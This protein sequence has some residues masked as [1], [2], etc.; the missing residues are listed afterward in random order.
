MRALQQAY[1]AE[2]DVDE[3]MAIL[4]GR[5]DALR[6]QLGVALRVER[7]RQG[8]SL[9][10][11]ARRIGCSKGMLHDVE[12]GRRWS[13][14]FVHLACEALGIFAPRAAAKGEG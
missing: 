8:V 1:R 2:A 12:K 9:S 3:H 11:L 5:R 7:E 10:E 14:A 6:R 13:T 4:L